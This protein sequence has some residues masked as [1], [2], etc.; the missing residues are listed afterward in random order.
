M[1]LVLYWSNAGTML[2]KPNYYYAYPGVERLLLL[3]H[4]AC[5]RR[6]ILYVAEEAA[7]QLLK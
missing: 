3:L 4:K 5:S 6:Y 2:R 7:C 1:L